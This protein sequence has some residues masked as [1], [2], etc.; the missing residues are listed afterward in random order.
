[1][2]IDISLCRLDKLLNGARLAIIREAK[3]FQKGLKV[4]D[5]DRESSLF[6]QVLDLRGAQ[7][8]PKGKLEDA[9]SDCCDHSCSVVVDLVCQVHQLERCKV[10]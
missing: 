10:R 1:M 6:E 4:S 8:V 2:W 3:L 7:M 5:M 9:V